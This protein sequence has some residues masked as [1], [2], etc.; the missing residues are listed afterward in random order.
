[1]KRLDV[2]DLSVRINPPANLTG[3][4]VAQPDLLSDFLP[5]A[6]RDAF[7]PDIRPDPGVQCADLR[8]QRFQAHCFR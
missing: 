2:I 7:R 1:M 3:E 5:F 6:P 8:F 4:L